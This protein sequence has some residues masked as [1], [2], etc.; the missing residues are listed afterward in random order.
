MEWKITIS[1]YRK[2]SSEIPKENRRYSIAVGYV[3]KWEKMWTATTTKE[4]KF[5]WAVTSDGQIK[6]HANDI[7]KGHFKGQ[8]R[9]VLI[10]LD[11]ELMF[12]KDNLDKY[13][14]L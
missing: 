5:N 6:A 2:K 14:F 3:K 11:G 8:P 7:W 13:F 9:Q 12:G 1:R 10:F 4:F